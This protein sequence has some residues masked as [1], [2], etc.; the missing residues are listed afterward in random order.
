MKMSSSIDNP[1]AAKPAQRYLKQNDERMA[2]LA[3]PVNKLLSRLLAN[4]ISQ[5]VVQ[6]VFYSG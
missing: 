4:I 1:V 6:F 5:T 2:K 3:D